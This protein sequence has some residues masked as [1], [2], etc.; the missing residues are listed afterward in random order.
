M[1]TCL[2]VDKLKSVKF[3]TIHTDVYFTTGT[4]RP[5]NKISS[6]I[7]TIIYDHINPCHQKFINVQFR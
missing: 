3:I 5:V 1:Y 2:P 7:P 4:T 6:L